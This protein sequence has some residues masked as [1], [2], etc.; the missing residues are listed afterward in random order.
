MIGQK[1]F[2]GKTEGR[3]AAMQHCATL[4]MNQQLPKR[5]RHEELGLHV[6]PAVVP[7]QVSVKLSL[8]PLTKKLSL[9]QRSLVPKRL[10]LMK[11][12]LSRQK[13][14]APVEG[15]VSVQSRIMASMYVFNRSKMVSDLDSNRD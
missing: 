12:E 11:M 14:S 9:R 6:V 4:V 8:R 7:Y 13:R 2:S 1:R 3:R 15:S 5:A 10:H